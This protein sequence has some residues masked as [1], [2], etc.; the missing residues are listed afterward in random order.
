MTPFEQISQHIQVACDALELTTSEQEVL[1]TPYCIHEKTLSVEVGEE[2]LALPAYRVQF[3]NARGPY[4]GGIRFHQDANLDEVKALAAAMAVKCAVV[5]IPLGG[6]KGGVTFNPKEHSAQTLQRVARAYAEAMSDFIGVDQDIPAPDVYTNAQIMSW[7]LD[8]YEKKTKKSEPGMIT[9]KPLAIGGSVG[10]DTATA[11]GGV[12]VL[13]ELLSHH[14]MKPAQTTVAVQG[15]G[16]AGATVAKL[17]HRAGY[18]IVAV[19]DSQG[20]LYS[21][22]GLDPV[23][24]ERTKNEHKAVTSLYCQA[25]VCDTQAMTTDEVQVLDRDAI[26][27]LECDV[28]VPAALD[29]VITESNAEDVQAKVILELANNPTTPEADAILENKN[30]IVLPDVLVNAGGVT[31]SYFEWVQNRQQYYWEND[32]VQQRLKKQMV[33]AYLAVHDLVQEKD[34]SYRTAAYQVGVAKIVE[35]MRLKGHL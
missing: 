24:I 35:A 25:G 28:L 5:G 14:D 27:S 1:Q 21:P 10:R 31:V 26:L 12:Y 13:E 22:R 2:T 34:V 30:V 16:N 6:A 8:A 11:Q 20:T 32:E 15:F 9:G 17:L 7:M 29:N 33:T 19:S 4:K 3:N 18:T 23:A